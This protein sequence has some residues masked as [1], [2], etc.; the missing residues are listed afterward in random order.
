[1]SWILFPAAFVLALFSSVLKNQWNV[2]IEYFMINVMMILVLSTC[3]WLYYHMRFKKKQL[4]FGEIIGI[5]DF[6]FFLIPGVCFSPFNFCLFLIVSLIIAL[7]LSLTIKMENKT[8]P[9]AGYQ[10]LCLAVLLVLKFVFSL[11][12]FNDYWIYQWI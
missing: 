7:L 10:A 9:L 6:L 3:L 1:V 11:N 2:I 4:K 8:V 5:G 12:F